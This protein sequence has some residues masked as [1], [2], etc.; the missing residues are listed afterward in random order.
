MGLNQTEALI[1]ELLLEMGRSKAREVVEKAEL[2]RGN[3]YNALLSLQTMGFIQVV[4]GK[5]TEYEAVDPG[6]LSSLIDRRRKEIEQ[7]EAE[8]K[9]AATQMLSTFRLSTGKP[10]IQI[11]EGFE[12]TKKALYDSLQSKGEI[13]TYLDPAALSQ[14][15]ADLNKRYVTE[16]RKRGIH[17]RIL[18]PDNAAAREYL[19]VGGGEFTEIRLAKGLSEHFKTAMEIYDD[20]VTLLTMTP[21]RNI[22][23]IL[24][25]PNITSLMRAQFEFVWRRS[26]S[27]EPVAHRHSPPSTPPPSPSQPP[28]PSPPISPPS[29]SPQNNG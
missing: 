13:L 18:L 26:A 4:E 24:T 8:Y 5:Q 29:S 1:Y 25:D 3:V 21:E 6:R 10:A 23:V 20:T 7:I 22:S 15:I 9:E 12:G 19:K 2:G 28:P 16:R 27:S 17:K 14:E 11:Y